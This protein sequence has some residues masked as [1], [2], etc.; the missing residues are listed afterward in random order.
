MRGKIKL[1]LYFLIRDIKLKYAGSSIGIAW[2]IILPLLQIIL[3]WFVFSGILKARPYA[4]SEMP[5][6]FFLL[7]SLFFWMAFSEGALRSSFVIVEN[8]ELVKKVNF[9]NVIL[10]FSATFSTYFHHLI[11]FTIFFVFYILKDGI[12][13]MFLLLV[14][15]V[16]SSKNPFHAL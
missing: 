3:F 16:M 13:V 6:I 15:V 14:P 10:P 1:L 8:S 4:N 2:S 11:G 9:P 7:S 5:Y 12:S